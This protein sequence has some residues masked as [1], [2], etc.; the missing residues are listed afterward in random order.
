MK[1]PK[2]RVARW[3][4]ILSPFD[5]YVEY[6]PGPKHTNADYMSRCNN[7]R[8]CECNETDNLEYLKCD[9]CKK[10]QKRAIDME[11]SLKSMSSYFHLAFD[12]ILLQFD[13]HWHL[14]LNKIHPCPL[15]NPLFLY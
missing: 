1:E 8:D 5:F 15:E 4:E 14:Y 10:C 9:P 3:L 12:S 11:S 7:P 2:G 13:S 6:R